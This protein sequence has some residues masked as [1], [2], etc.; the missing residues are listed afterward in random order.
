LSFN[1]HCPADVSDHDMHHG[2]ARQAAQQSPPYGLAK[3]H[4]TSPMPNCWVPGGVRTQ[5]SEEEG[6]TELFASP[7]LEHRL[8]MKSCMRGPL[9]VAAVVAGGGEKDHRMPGSPRME[10]Y[11]VAGVEGVGAVAARSRTATLH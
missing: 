3:T 8:Y 1:E 2:R 4:W 9:G 10:R 6:T 7:A 5:V 11:C